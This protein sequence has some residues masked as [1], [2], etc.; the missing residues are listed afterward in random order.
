[1]PVH[2]YTNDE[3]VA[4]DPVTL[5]SR[6]DVSDPLHLHP[7]DFV[8]LTVVYVKLK[9]TKNY[10]VWSCATLLALEGKNKTSFIDGS[11]KRSNS[12][13][14][15]GKQWDRRF[16]AL[17]KQFD[18]LIELPRFLMGLDDTYM[19]IRSSIFSRE[20]LPNVRSAYAIISSEES[21]RVASGEN[22]H[23]THTDK[24]LD[25]VYDISYLRTKVGHPNGTEAFISKIG[26]LRLSNGFGHVQD[27]CPKNIG[28][29]VAKNLKKPSQAC[30]GVSIRPKVGF[31]QAKQVYRPVSKK[32]NAN[33]SGNKKKD[34]EPTKDVSNSNP[35]DVLNSV[36]ND[37]DLGPNG[38]TS[39]LAS[40]KANSN[41]SSFWNVGSSSTST[42]PIVEKIN[43]IER[44]TVKIDDPNITM[45]EYI[46]LEEEKACRLGKVYNWET[47]TYG[48]IW[49]DEDVHDLRYVETEFPAIVLNDTLMSEP[50]VSSPNN[51]EIDFRI[52]FD[53]SDDEDYTVI[54]DKNSFSYKI[55][56]VN[57]LKTDSENYNEKVNMPSF[58]SPEPTVSCFDDLDFFKDFDNEFPAIIYNNAQTSK[59]DL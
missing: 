22:Q 24:E 20:T 10:Q 51:N 17:W 38:E 12:D 6:L 39:N 48:K 18:A 40:K 49:Y 4:D 30:R 11:C 57:D 23:M 46:R 35:F 33:T 31:K 54:F 36:E 25:N 41:G 13:E 28:L 5:I 37:V 52:S 50:T 53:K 14:V 29:C 47:A 21:H 9:V 42:T 56:C 8:A 7:N 55:I 34:V 15:L 16:N 59:S 32:T 3:F 27:E 44:L 43:K 19:Q 1:M 26:N 58:P 2:G 45:E